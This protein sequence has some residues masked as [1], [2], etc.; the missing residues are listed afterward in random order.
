[1]Q[2][3]YFGAI[4][5]GSN[6]V[7]LLIKRVNETESNPLS[8][9]QLVRVP[10]RLG[11]DAFIKGEISPRRGEDLLLLMQAYRHL[12]DIYRVE[13]YRACATSAMREASN[14]QELVERIARV[15]GITVEIISG[16]EEARLASRNS[17]RGIV[18]SKGYYLFVDVGGGSTELTFIHDGETVHRA[19]FDIGTVRMLRGVVHSEEIRRFERCVREESADDKKYILIGTGGNIN[20]LVRLAGKKR[21][22]GLWEMKTDELLKLYEEFKGLTVE[23]RMFKYDIKPDRADVMEPAARIFLTIA[24]NLRTER[25]LVPTAG[26]SDGIMDELYRQSLER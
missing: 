24:D 21:D 3:R 26:I 10:L 7:R 12:L 13:S 22:D 15:A 19:S 20:R 5:I 18:G 25:I 6:A 4:D 16:D 17:I 11:E 1:M 2:E 9:V 14:G 8:K 23:E